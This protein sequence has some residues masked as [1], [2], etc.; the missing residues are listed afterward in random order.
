MK[1]DTN[2]IVDNRNGNGSHAKPANT[3][4]SVFKVLLFN[5]YLFIFCHFAICNTRL[6]IYLY[7]DR[8]NKKFLKELS[9]YFHCIHLSSLNVRHFGM[10][11]A[12]EL[13]MWRRGH[14]QWHHLCTKFHE[15][16]K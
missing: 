15:P 14:L 4:T 10:A 7:E 11:E 2:R 5:F 6:G 12:T 13:K 9:A 16:T 1:P 3:E 8:I